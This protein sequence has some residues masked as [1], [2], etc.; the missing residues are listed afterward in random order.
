MPGFTLS[1]AARPSCGVFN[2]WRHACATH[3]CLLSAR[4]PH[5]RWTGFYILEGDTLIL[6]PYRG[7]PTEHVRIPVGRGVCGTAVAED[8]NLVVDDVTK[9][10]NYLACSADT[11]SEIVVLVRKHGRVVAQIDVDSDRPGA[12]SAEDERLLEA[13]AAR[14]GPIF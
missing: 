1:S 4:L 14:I 5:F 2:R 3:G 12:F 8:R 7:A 11:R 9:V 13:I 10:D 6:G